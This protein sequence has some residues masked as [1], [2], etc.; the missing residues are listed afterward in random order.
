MILLAKRP[1]KEIEVGRSRLCS[2][3]GVGL[4]RVFSQLEETKYTHIA[5]SS[6]AGE[7]RTTG[8][9]HMPDPEV[10]EIYAVPLRVS[11][12]SSLSDVFDIPVKGRLE[13]FLNL[14]IPFDCQKVS[15]PPIS[16]D[17]ESN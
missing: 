4:K 11:E 9:G 16:H 17:L 14:S 13:G 1:R 6:I 15:M 3:G 8:V 7:G 5:V 10:S 2:D 12:D